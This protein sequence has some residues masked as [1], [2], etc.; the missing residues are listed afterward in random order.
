MVSYPR[1][2]VPGQAGYQYIVHI[3]F[4]PTKALEPK[5]KLNKDCS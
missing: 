2:T 5:Q 1:Q 3:S 4:I